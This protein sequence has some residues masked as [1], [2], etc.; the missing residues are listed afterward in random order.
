MSAEKVRNSETMFHTLTTKLVVALIR[1]C[2]R[3]AFSSRRAA[4]HA[5]KF[6]LAVLNP[7]KLSKLCNSL[8]DL[9]RYLG[10]QTWEIFHVW[11]FLWV[12]SSESIVL[13]H[14]DFGL[15]TQDFGLNY[16]NTINFNSCA[17]RQA[18]RLHGRARRFV[19]AEISCVNLVHRR[20]ICH[21]R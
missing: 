2:N 17:A 4:M 5:R 20:K 13:S 9:T 14:I 21:I 7:A 10:C 18:R 11:H 12:Q 6:A 19:F 3:S 8:W 15:L 16:R 1:I